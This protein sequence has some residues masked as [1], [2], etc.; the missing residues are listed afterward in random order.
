MPKL[1]PLSF[2]FLKTLVEKPLITT[3]STH[4]HL[5]HLFFLLCHTAMA[6]ITD[7]VFLLSFILFH[8]MHDGLNMPELTTLYT[9]PSRSFCANQRV[10]QQFNLAR[11][12][13]LY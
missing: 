10:L 12:L 9:C 5:K 2:I 8:R 3:H 1:Q 6:C 13:Y 11:S 7:L 4:S